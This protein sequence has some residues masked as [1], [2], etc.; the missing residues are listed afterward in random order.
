MALG[1]IAKAQG[2]TQIL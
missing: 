1:D 2:M